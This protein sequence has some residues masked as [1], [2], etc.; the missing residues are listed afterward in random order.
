MEI[1]GSYTISASPE[2][3]WRALNDPD[4]L[5]LC[6]PGIEVLDKKSETEFAATATAKVGPVKAKFT[7]NVTLTNLDPPRGY[8]ITGEGQGGVAGFA[9]GNC[10]I[11]LREIQGQT[12]LSYVA[13]ARVGGK[14]AQIG[15]RMVAGVARKMADDFFGAFA[16]EVDSKGLNKVGDGP[17]TDGTKPKIQQTLQGVVVAPRFW[18]PGLLIISALL[19]WL[20]S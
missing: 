6:I 11:T 19:W 9:K 3:V 10:D 17:S 2:D 16:Q 4:V 14:L 18:I 15:S 8:T 12:E 1:K 13:E 7:G 5:R 20:S